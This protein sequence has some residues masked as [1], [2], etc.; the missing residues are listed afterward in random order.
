MKP[1]E[2][3]AIHEVLYRAAHG[4]DSHNIEMLTECFAEDSV[5]T[6]RVGGG[7]LIGPYDGQVAVLNF[8]KRASERQTDKRLHQ[9]SN[10][11]FEKEGEEQAF[12]RSSLTLFATENGT[13]QLLSTGIY[14]DEVVK[15][16]GSWKISKR[17]LDIEL[18]V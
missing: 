9:I 2:K 14:R 18:P 10:I 16:N 5:M 13:C 3:L 7:D 12:A 6:I 1:E 8:M 4:Y 15:V 17:H 11:F